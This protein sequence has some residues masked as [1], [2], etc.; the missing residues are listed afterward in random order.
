MFVFVRLYAEGNSSWSET[1][2]FTTV[3]VV[4][5][6]DPV[7]TSSSS[8]LVNENSY[9]V[10]SLVASDSDSQDSVTGYSVS[11]G[12]DRSLFSVTSGGVLTFNSAPDYEVPSDSGGNN[13]YDLVVTATRRYGWS[14]SD[15]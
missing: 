7:F 4:V 5:N 2:S 10:G 6:I 14:R 3:H 15:C 9:D 13:V 1:A 11:D 8:F 12:V